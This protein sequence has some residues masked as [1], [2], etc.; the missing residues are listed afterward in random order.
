MYE[1][2]LEA[3]PTGV[4]DLAVTVD[5]Q[6][7]QADADDDSL[8]ASPPTVTLTLTVA[9]T[10]DQRGT[11]AVSSDGS[12]TCSMGGLGVTDDE[13][14]SYFRTGIRL[15]EDL[16]PHTPYYYSTSQAFLT[17]DDPADLSDDHILILADAVDPDP[18][19][20][21]GT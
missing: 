15:L 16:V 12:L 13:L 19:S 11:V 1:H 2:Y 9:V 3:T 5:E 6:R 18:H 10:T 21:S 14:K 17:T 20:N 7:T 8:Y 4:T